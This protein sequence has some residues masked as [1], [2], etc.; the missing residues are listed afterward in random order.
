M[1]LK[2]KF[3]IATATFFRV[4]NMQILCVGSHLNEIIVPPGNTAIYW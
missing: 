4:K 3:L 1:F 2:T